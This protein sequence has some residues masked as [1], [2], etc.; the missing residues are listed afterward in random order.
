MVISQGYAFSVLLFCFTT[1]FPPWSILKHCSTTFSFFTCFTESCFCF[2][3]GIKQ[4]FRLLFWNLRFM[5]KYLT[6]G[7][8]LILLT[9]REAA[10]RVVR[11]ISTLMTGDGVWPSTEKYEHLFETFQI[12]T[13]W[14]WRPLETNSW[15]RSFSFPT[16]ISNSFSLKC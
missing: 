9:K 10:S 7:M 6:A 4:D 8:I 13:L 12:C 14:E 11:K 5:L 16:W 3:H 15:T 1:L 2:Q